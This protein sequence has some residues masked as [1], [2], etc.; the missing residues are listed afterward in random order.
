MNL[1]NLN[2][3]D[4]VSKTKNL[5]SEERKLTTEILVHL[6]EIE[7]RRIH[8]YFGYSSLHEFCVKHLG[9]SDGSAHRR[10]SAM[11]LIKEI[12]ELETKIKEGSLTITNASIVHDFFKAEKK[13]NVTY[14]ET[15]KIE[16]IEKIATLST[17]HTEK[18]LATISP[19][20]IP[21]ERTRLLTETKTEIKVVIDEKT[22][23]KLEKIKE[24]LS[25]KLDNTYGDLLDKMA[26]IVLEKITPK[27]SAQKLH[28]ETDSRYIPK[29]IKEEILTRDD[30]QCTFISPTTG[31]RCESKHYLEIDHIKPYATGGKT[32][33]DNLRLLCSNHNKYEATQILGIEVMKRYIE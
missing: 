3:L 33:K 22:K 20:P 24:L 19:N 31:K 8:L 13:Q 12:P 4:L 28:K 6:R 14:S 29:Q 18:V 9:Y 25:N 30:N 11:R 15:K 16:I 23:V 7:K 27:A 17:R 2:N 10:I 1:T 5:V 26:D 21:R 32:T